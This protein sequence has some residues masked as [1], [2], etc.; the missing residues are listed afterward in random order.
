M[1]SITGHGDAKGMEFF[2]G[3][4]WSEGSLGGVHLHSTAISS[5][6]ASIA[7]QRNAVTIISSDPVTS[8][9]DSADEKSS[10][11]LKYSGYCYAATHNWVSGYNGSNSTVHVPRSNESTPAEFRSAAIHLARRRRITN[12]TS[13]SAKV[14]TKPL[15]HPQENRSSKETNPGNDIDYAQNKVT[16]VDEGVAAQLNS[17]RLLQMAEQLL[18]DAKSAV[19]FPSGEVA[20][21]ENSVLT[22]LAEKAEKLMASTVCYMDQTLYSEEDVLQCPTGCGS[23][24]RGLFCADLSG[25]NSTEAIPPSNKDSTPS[26]GS[27]R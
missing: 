11:T 9:D 10:N 13:S 23:N 25:Y 2:G 22:S 7:A 17:D 3:N 27:E 6:A 16:E 4:E 26:S 21:N 5:S 1:Q 12:G 8:N 15:L 14:Y 24:K 18:Q 20:L 19:I